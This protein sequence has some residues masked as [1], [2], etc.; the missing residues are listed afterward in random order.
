MYM[1]FE[2]ANLHVDSTGTPFRQLGFI[3]YP[4]TSSASTR[5]LEER[6]LV[7][8]EGDLV[9]GEGDLVGGEG[10]LVSGGGGLSFKRDCR[11]VPYLCATKDLCDVLLAR[12]L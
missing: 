2:L 9:G 8:G 6:L 10:D 3:Q 12:P 4:L 5:G 11:R 1:H 7:G